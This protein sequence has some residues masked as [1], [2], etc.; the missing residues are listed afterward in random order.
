MVRPAAAPEELL[1]ERP[2]AQ[3]G[4]ALAVRLV[5]APAELQVAQLAE[6][7]GDHRILAI[8]MEMWEKNGHSPYSDSKP[9][10]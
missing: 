5:A 8:P 7:L 4:V 3:P 9:Q 1:V 2:A 6:V 10:Q